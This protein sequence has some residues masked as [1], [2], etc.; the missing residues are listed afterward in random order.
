MQKMKFGD[1]DPLI[2][3]SRGVQLRATRALNLGTPTLRVAAM[4]VG[5]FISQSVVGNDPNKG[6]MIVQRKL[7]PKHANGLAQYILKSLLDHT[8]HVFVT[9]G[10]EIP[11]EVEGISIALGTQE[12]Y[13]M[14][15]FIV[16]LRRDVKDLEI[17]PVTPGDPR[18]A[19]EFI[20]YLGANEI[21]YVSDGQHRREALRIILEALL[22][23]LREG[24]YTR[25]HGLFPSD[26]KTVD[27]SAEYFWQRAHSLFLENW[28]V[29]LDIHCGLNE[30]QE[31]QL[32][33]DTNNLQKQVPAGLAQSFDGGNPINQ[34]TQ[35][36]IQGLFA[37][38]GLEVH[39]Q[40]KVDWKTNAGYYMARHMLT[41]INARLFLNSN[42]AKGASPPHIES[43]RPDAMRFWGA[44]SN[45][46]NFSIRDESVVAQPALIKSIARVFHEICWAKNLALDRMTV[47]K[48]L[49]DLPTLD[50]SHSNQLWDI[51][52]LEGEE[53]F[54]KPNQVGKTLRQYLNVR[55]KEKEIARTI[56]DKIHFGTRHNESILVLP[57]IIRYLANLPVSILVIK[58]W[59]KHL[60]DLEKQLVEGNKT[61]EEEEDLR[62]KIE[63]AKKHLGLVS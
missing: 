13:A 36:L 41:G 60:V 5:L 34:F 59:E 18:K 58:E 47:N 11:D 32:F 51:T 54:D 14:G 35:E 12:Y 20:L 30:R 63:E 56:A 26:Y 45:I 40:L 28:T 27:T 52:H 39:D 6:E 17:T 53:E 42:T 25:S 4:D 24:K 10:R 48:F 1:L 33:H 8:K 62:H 3:S 37:E 7:D 44:V 43:R 22:M 15:G 49:T 19:K 16:T 50:F 21:L 9:E 2:P 23:I 31:R 55:W 38:K 46:P 29:Q 61:R 57:H